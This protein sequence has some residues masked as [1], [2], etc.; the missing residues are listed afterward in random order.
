MRSTYFNISNFRYWHRSLNP[1]KLIE[2]QFSHLSRN[3]TMQRQIKLLKLNDT[4][5]IEGLRPLT[6]QDVAGACKLLNEVRQLICKL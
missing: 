4:T 3:M 2:V 5:K 6:S 1:K